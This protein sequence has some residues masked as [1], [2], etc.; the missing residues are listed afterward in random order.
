MEKKVYFDMDGTLNR[1]YEVEGWL[2]DLEAEN[3]RPYLEAAPMLNFALFARLAHK[4][5]KAGWKLGI[6]S[7]TSKRGTERYHEAV[8]QAKRKWL[9]RHLHSVKWDEIHIVP[10]GTNKRSVCGSGILFDDEERN[11]NDWGENAFTP[12]EILPTLKRLIQGA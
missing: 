10:Y 8:V 7:W 9:A 5:Q 12:N 6:I 3:V 1:F 11:R 4:L 2:A